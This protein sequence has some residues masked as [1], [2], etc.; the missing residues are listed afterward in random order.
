MPTRSIGI[1]LTLFFG[2]LRTEHPSQ[3]HLVSI[4]TIDLTFNVCYINH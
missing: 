2:S 1:S 4:A 3:A